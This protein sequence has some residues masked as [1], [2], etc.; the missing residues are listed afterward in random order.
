MNMATSLL[1][2]K[3]EEAIFSKLEYSR[4]HVVSGE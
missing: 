4:A 3:E 1:T 2:G